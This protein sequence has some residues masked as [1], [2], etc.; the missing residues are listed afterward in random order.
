MH[1]YS[2]GAGVIHPELETEAGGIHPGTWEVLYLTEGTARMTWSHLTC[3]A[4]APAVFVLKPG[5]PHTLVAVSGSVAY[6]F[7]VGGAEH[8]ENN[9][10]DGATRLALD[11]ELVDDW[12]MRQS[13]PDR[14]A[15]H[16]L[17]PHL[18]TSL[19]QLRGYLSMHGTAAAQLRRLCELELEKALLLILAQAESERTRGTA[20]AA[21]ISWRVDGRGTAVE[22]MRDYLEWRYK[23]PITINELAGEVHLD[24]SYAIRLFRE[25]LGVTPTQ[26]M[27][28]LRMK[29]AASYLSGSD[30]PIHRIAELTGFHSVHYFTRYFTKT[31]GSSPARWRTELRRRISGETPG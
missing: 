10:A 22:R 12:N 27:L 25:Q 17:Y 11:P 14:L 18:L 28:Q 4:T 5:T 24:P 20:E 23:D 9:G 7:V 21:E 3:E 6:F 15:A 26:Y 29:A 30:L 1:I 31:F 2:H 13:Q 8:E 19:D 16:T